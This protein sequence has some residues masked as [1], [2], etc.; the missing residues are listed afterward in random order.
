MVAALAGATTEA[1]PRE[2]V[3]NL[4]DGYAATYERH[5][6]D[7]LG[8]RT[9]ALMRRMLAT[10][11][12][13][14]ARFRRALDLGCGTGL[15]GAAFRDV[16]GR[17]E[18]VDL[19]A[20]MVDQARAKGLYDALFVGDMIEYL[21]RPAGWEPL[22]D[23]IVAADVFA[24]VGH[25]EA[26]FAAARGRLSAGGLFVFSIE[27]LVRGGFALRQSGRYA[28]SSGYVRQLAGDHG[29]AIG[30]REVAIVRTEND[31]GIDGAVFVLVKVN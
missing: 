23:L 16:V 3:T 1:A 7:V 14:T 9:P 24:Y 25:L 11:R 4:F 27:T 2:Y 5:L 6:V 31:V 19:S 17:L 21:E 29:F 13:G 10:A 20:R 18:G 8:Y 30:G 22:S 12:P 26:T 15:V 28:H